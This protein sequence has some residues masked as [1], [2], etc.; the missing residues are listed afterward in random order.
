MK[1]Y[2]EIS[3]SALLKSKDQNV[4]FVDWGSTRKSFWY[5][6]AVE[7]VPEIAKVVA[8]FI[9]F[10]VD[11]ASLE[12]EKTTIIG[13]SL[14][15]HIAGLAAKNLANGK[16]NK[17]I[18]LDPAGPGFLFENPGS[19][20]DGNDANYVECIHTG[21]IFGIREPI[22]QVDFYVNGGRDQPG[23]ETLFGTFDVICSHSRA[24]EVFIEALY[25]QKAFFGQRCGSLDEALDRN[26]HDN[27]GAFLNGKQNAEEALSGIFHIS[28]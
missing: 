9:D 11:S 16:V 21:Y 7:R 18:G 5:P 6:E 15:A 13:F 26:C 27:P 4:F 8:E 1:N 25:L 2:F 10:M 22:C 23:C 24:V 12:L 14:G 17:I 19:R 3:S 28:T 20:L